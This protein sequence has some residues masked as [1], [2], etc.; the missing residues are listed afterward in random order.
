MVYDTK[1]SGGEQFTKY[2]TIAGYHK[3]ENSCWL[4]IRSAASTSH[5][6]I[7]LNKSLEPLIP[8]RKFS[9]VEAFILRK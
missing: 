9:L 1:Q 4:I 5:Y 2:I 3:A 7:E 6:K 8:V